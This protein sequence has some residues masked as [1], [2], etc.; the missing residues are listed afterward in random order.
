MECSPP[1]CPITAPPCKV[2]CAQLHV[3]LGQQPQDQAQAQGGQIH[4]YPTA[5]RKQETVSVFI[6]V[7]LALAF[8]ERVFGPQEF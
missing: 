8:K 7:V 2:V 5:A 4:L 6:L 1:R 3:G